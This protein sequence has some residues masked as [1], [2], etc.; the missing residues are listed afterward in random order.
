[1]NNQV[2]VSTG[3]PIGA[4]FSS[5]FRDLVDVLRNPLAVVGGVLGIALTGVGFWLVFGV[6]ANSAS[7][8]DEANAEEDEELEIEFE[9]GALVKLGEQFEEPPIPEKIVIPEMRQEIEEEEPTP[10][11]VTEDEKAAPKTEPEPEE[12]PDKPIKEPKKDKPPVEKKDKKLPTTNL[13]PP[14]PN[15]PFNDKPLNVKV[16]GDPFGD[17][18]GWSDIAKDGDPWAT[19][20]MKALNGMKVGSFAAKG[21]TGDFKFQLTICKDGTIKQVAKKGGSADAELQNAVRLALEQLE[22][23]KPPAKVLAL[24]KS[25]CAKIKYT[26]VWSGS[27]VK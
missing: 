23:P 8:E 4:L 6:M 25:N 3:N 22:I 14:P 26:F 16:K 21:K 9:P 24:M 19:S 11:T 15:T 1:M 7:A 18:G 13:P 20:V 12:P 2:R 17:P 10:A 5:L 27:G